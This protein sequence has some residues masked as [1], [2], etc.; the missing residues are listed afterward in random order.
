MANLGK[1][2]EIIEFKESTA[3]FDKACKAIVGMLNKSGHGTIYFGVK[4][5]GDVIGH[6]IGKDTLSTLTDRIRQNI[7][8][9]IYP[10][11]SEIQIENMK[12]I[13]VTFSGSNKPYAYKG[14]FYI[15]VEQQ[16]LQMD[17]MVIREM[18]KSSHEYNEN[19]ENELTEYGS[20][21]IDEE[22]L[23]LY[24]RQS[25]AMGRIQ[26]FKHT[27]TELMVMLELMRDNKLTNAGLY[28]FGKK[29]KIVLKAVEYPTSERVDPIDLKRFENNIFNSINLM[30]NFIY[31]KMRW[32]VVVD[33]MQRKELPEIPIKAIREIVINS[34]VHC[35]YYGDSDFQ[36]TVDPNKIEI[37]NPGSF[38][39]GYS[40]EEYI[41]DIIPSRSKHKIIQSILFKAFDIETLGRGFKRMNIA[42]EEAGIKWT[43]RKYDFGFSFSF[44][45]PSINNDL[46]ATNNISLSTSASTLFEWMRTH[47]GIVNSIEEA[48]KIIKKQERQTKNIIKELVDKKHVKRIGSNK[49]G[50]WEIIK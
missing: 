38:V 50:Y 42:C 21:Y 32:R 48:S 22:A 29:G 44:I 34:L 25:L 16:N 3:E 47:G 37:Y 36:I 43:Y 11:V 9:D 20:D 39:D 26:D 1:E 7:K 18:I 41:N 10:T 13:S 40:P 30:T 46:I 28:L 17:P 27:S 35:D 19:W 8:P 2:N 14:A 23:E 15:R 33:G 24:Y 6:I 5:S 45:R 31:S 49:N 12:I 4:D